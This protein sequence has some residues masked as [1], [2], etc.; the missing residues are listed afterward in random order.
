MIKFI[1]SLVDRF[2]K[3]IR[4]EATEQ[5]VEEYL[6]ELRREEDESRRRDQENEALRLA[7][8]A[9]FASAEAARERENREFSEEC[10][11]E[12]QAQKEQEIRDQE[13]EEEQSRYRSHCPFCGSPKI[14]N[15]C[16]ACDDEFGRY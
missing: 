3:N 1:C 7:D 15:R 11:A 10:G 9:R 4:N 16:R 2:I 8:E 13:W 5:D 6:A 14:M 12:D